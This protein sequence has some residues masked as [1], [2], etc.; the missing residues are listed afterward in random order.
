HRRGYQVAMR[1]T[2]VAEEIE[3]IA[4]DCTGL[5]MLGPHSKTSVARVAALATPLVRVGWLDPLEPADLVS[6]TDHEAGSAVADYLLRL[7][8]RVIAYV[9]GSP[10]YR[11]RRERF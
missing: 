7:G 3:A 6:G 4:R 11:G 8:H 9:H 1:W 10:V 2:H 5:I